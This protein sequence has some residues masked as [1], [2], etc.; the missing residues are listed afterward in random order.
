[1]RFF[2]KLKNGLG[3]TRNSLSDKM[4]SVFSTFRKVDE[5]YFDKALRNNDDINIYS[6]ILNDIINNDYIDIDYEERNKTIIYETNTNKKEE[7]EGQENKNNIK[8][9]KKEVKI[10]KRRNTNKNIKPKEKTDKDIIKKEGKTIIKTSGAKNL[11]EL[12]G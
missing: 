12:L 1:M 5:D 4:N 9:V 3:K 11:K 8:E 10:K 7:K 2:D 6:T